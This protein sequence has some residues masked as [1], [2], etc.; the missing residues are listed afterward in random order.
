MS[1]NLRQDKQNNIKPANLPHE[2]RLQRDRPKRIVQS[3]PKQ[4]SG[5]CRLRI[6]RP[7]GSGSPPT[8]PATA[9]R[10]VLWLRRPRMY[11]SFVFKGHHHLVPKHNTP[12]TRE[13]K[14]SHPMTRRSFPG[15]KRWATDPFGA[16]G[17]PAVFLDPQCVPKMNDGWGGAESK[18]QRSLRWRAQPAVLTANH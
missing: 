6:F 1:S 7:H 16:S 15:A 4:A 8:A 3:R 18:T 14:G 2:S 10:P 12:N 5:V 13:C 17:F 9:R 11:V